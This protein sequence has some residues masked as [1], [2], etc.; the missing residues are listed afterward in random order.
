MFLT[1]QERGWLHHLLMPPSVQNSYVVWQ[2][3]QLVI[4]HVDLAFEREFSL[5]KTVEQ[6]LIYFREYNSIIFLG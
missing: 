1:A 3:K 2:N 4:W 6:P 5:Q